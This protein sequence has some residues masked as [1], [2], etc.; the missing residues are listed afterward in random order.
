MNE[1]PP[2]QHNL[3][4]LTVSELSQAIKRTLEGSFERVRVRGEISGFKRAASGHMYMMLKDESAAM[5]AVVWR[6]NA[7]RLGLAPEDGMEVIA[8]GRITGYAERSSYQ[9]IV[10][11][12][13]Y[14][15]AGALLGK[16]GLVGGLLKNGLNVGVGVGATACGCN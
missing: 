6:T 4:E 9:L 7:A 3:G 10:D 8:T 13:E 16:N 14:A 5:K 2:V 15:G 1:S 11:R 12:I